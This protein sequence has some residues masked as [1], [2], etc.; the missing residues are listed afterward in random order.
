MYFS[1]NP[2]KASFLQCHPLQSSSSLLP[3][4]SSKMPIWCHYFQV[5][6][7]SLA[8]ISYSNCTFLQL[9]A[10]TWEPEHLSGNPRSI[11]DRLILMQELLSYLISVSVTHCKMRGGGQGVGYLPHR[12]FARIKWLNIRNALQTVPGTE[13]SRRKCLLIKQGSNISL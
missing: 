3:E 12:T 9:R 5:K 13:Q 10:G 1:W 11:P 2:A 4:D 8:H 6:I 7:L